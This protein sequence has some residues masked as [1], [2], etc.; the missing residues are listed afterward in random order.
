V[1]VVVDAVVAIVDER[2]RSWV[3]VYEVLEEW[4]LL[5]FR[6]LGF[7]IACDPVHSYL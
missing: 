7:A 3:C 2:E 5:G 4:V 1:E 6:V